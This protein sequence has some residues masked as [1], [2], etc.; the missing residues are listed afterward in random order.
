MLR[1]KAANLLRRNV[2]TLQNHRIVL[3][4][5]LFIALKVNCVRIGLIINATCVFSSTKLRQFGILLL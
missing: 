5:I 4:M 1:S 3:F 2:G